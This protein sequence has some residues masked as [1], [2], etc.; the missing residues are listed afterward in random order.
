MA[1]TKAVAQVDEWAEVAQNAVRTGAVVDLSALYPSALHIFCCLSS[2]T[3]HTG[4]EILVEVSAAAAGNE[5]WH[6]L[7]PL[8]GPIGT[9]V[10]ADFTAT[11]PVGE[12]TIALTDPVTGNIHFDGKYKFVEHSTVAN[13]EVVYQTA[14]SADAGDT[15]TLRDGLTNEQTAAASDLYDIHDAVASAVGNYTVEL[16]LWAYRARI[17]YNNTYDLDGSTVH[18]QASISKVTAI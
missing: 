17:T 10:K 5:D 16:P 12:T 11:E 2:T 1:L 8:V 3:A 15:I 4:T 6:P 14:N 9:A 7:C 13:C 18:T